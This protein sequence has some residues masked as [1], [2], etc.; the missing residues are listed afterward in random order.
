MHARCLAENAVTMDHLPD[1]QI[2]AMNHDM[3][4]DMVAM[5]D[6]VD[7]AV[8]REDLRQETLHYGLSHPSHPS[9]R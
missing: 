5:M 7:A 4:D 3:V 9:K 8:I 1:A 6:I 2:A